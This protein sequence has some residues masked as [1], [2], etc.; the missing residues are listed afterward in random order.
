MANTGPKR[1]TAYRKNERR[2][3]DMRTIWT[4]LGRRTAGG[5]LPGVVGAFVSSG[6]C[7]VSHG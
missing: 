7:G 2:N 3:P 6:H 5:I 1:F 4:G